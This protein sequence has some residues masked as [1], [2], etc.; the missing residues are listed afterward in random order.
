MNQPK[1]FGRPPSGERKQQV[2]AFL[3]P[4]LADWFMAIP[5]KERTAWLAEMIENTRQSGID[6][7]ID[8]QTTKTN[9]A[10]GANPAQ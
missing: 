9:P 2:F 7:H 10:E 4:D 6:S 1:K 5:P 3:P 8:S